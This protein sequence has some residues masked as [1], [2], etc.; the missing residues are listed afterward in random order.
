MDLLGSSWIVAVLYQILR[1]E[2]E[3]AADKVQA[4]LSIS[5]A[6]DRYRRPYPLEFH[7]TAPYALSFHICSQLV[8]SSWS[9]I[10]GLIGLK[11]NL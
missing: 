9:W 4:I 7:A 3:A 10:G 1:A 8:F 5:I 6:I 11:S 2:M